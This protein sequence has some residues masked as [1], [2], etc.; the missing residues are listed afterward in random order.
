M[1]RQI[2]IDEL[3]LRYEAFRMRNPRLEGELL[4]SIRERGVE[5][6]VFGVDTEQAPVL[7]DGFKRLRSARA[8]SLSRLPYEA[9]GEDAAEGLVRLLR[10]RPEKPLTILEQAAFLDELRATQGWS[11]GEMARQLSCSKGWVS[12]RLDLFKQLRPA[13][14]EKL[15]AGHFPAYAYLYSVLP[16]LRMNGTS[17]KDID[18]FVLAVSGKGLSVRQIDLLCRS[19]FEGSTALRE[20]ILAGR[21]ELVLREGQD[22]PA[23]AGVSAAEKRLLQEL[24]ALC[25][26]MRRVRALAGNKRLKSPAFHAQAGLVT[27]SILTDANAFLTT[28]RRLHAR[29]EQA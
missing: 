13:V 22:G 1:T 14:R 9:C 21:F 15:F 11:A 20:Q 23:A 10:M 6:P 17:G 3:D 2:E 26:G 29:S 7:L 4:C 24:E 18:R 8:L 12:M 5:E 28:I 19:C 16:F 27:A 25:K